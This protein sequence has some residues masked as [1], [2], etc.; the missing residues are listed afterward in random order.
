M[1][2]GTVVISVTNCHAWKEWPPCTS[3]EFE[4]FVTGSHHPQSLKNPALVRLSFITGFPAAL[5]T[6]ILKDET[7]V[8]VGAHPKT[9]ES[10]VK[11][12]KPF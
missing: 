6:P 8:P 1:D 10:D 7:V 5:I 3:Y 2:A 4:L 12:C 11:R 9:L